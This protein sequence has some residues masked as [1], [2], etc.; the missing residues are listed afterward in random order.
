MIKLLKTLICT[1]IL[2]LCFVPVKGQITIAPTNLFIDDGS[3]FGTYLVINGSNE[4]QEVSVEFIFGYSK[5]DKDGNRST[6][7]EDPEI[8]ER[9]SAHNWVRAF[10]RNFTI[11]PGERQV[12]RL[13]LTPPGSLEN[14]TYWARIKTTSAAQSTPIE[15]QNTESVSARVDINIE[16]ITGL[17]YKHG[18]VNTGIE[19]TGIRTKLS[20]DGYVTVL[21]DLLRTGNSPFL[22]SI[23]LEIKDA[24]GN[25]VAESFVSTTIY[26]DGTHRQE[27]DIS[28]LEPGIY[29]AQVS[30]E[31]QRNDVSSND[32][33]QMEPVSS[34]TQFTIR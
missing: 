5:T 15:V 16:Q 24:G 4:A 12:V 14:G 22:G 31:S 33:V 1:F 21:T 17:Y 26:F 25:V 28:E 3:R 20:E 2:G 27:V 19:I 32:I 18:E 30:F 10:P 8:E 7:Y 29:T 11:A 34:S 23:T 9:Y 13:R 6:I